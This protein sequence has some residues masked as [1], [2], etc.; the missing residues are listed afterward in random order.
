MFRVAA[1]L[2]S[3]PLFM[4][5]MLKKQKNPYSHRLVPQWGW[6]DLSCA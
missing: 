4:R 2:D 1:L 5:Q 6:C 3:K